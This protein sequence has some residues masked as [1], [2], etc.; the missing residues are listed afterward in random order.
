MLHITIVIPSGFL[1]YDLT[2]TYGLAS[3]M[4]QELV[5]ISFQMVVL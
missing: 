2:E 4:C 3:I 1:W 5:T